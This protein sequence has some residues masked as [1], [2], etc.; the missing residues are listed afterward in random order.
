M[1]PFDL[2]DV[3]DSDGSIHL[4]DFWRSLENI[5]YTVQSRTCNMVFLTVPSISSVF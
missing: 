2:E 1:V 4:G 3:V 5:G